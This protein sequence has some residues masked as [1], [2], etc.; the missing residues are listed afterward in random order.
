MIKSVDCLKKMKFSFYQT[1]CN[2][3]EHWWL[4]GIW[5]HLSHCQVSATPVWDSWTETTVWPGE[6]WEQVPPH[7]LGLSSCGASGCVSSVAQGLAPPFGVHVLLFTVHVGPIQTWRHRL[8][9]LLLW[10]PSSPR[11]PFYPNLTIFHVSKSE[12]T[13]HKQDDILIII[14][15]TKR[16][17]IVH[18]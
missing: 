2:K 15:F 13:N 10:R 7:G 3:D 5:A 16:F 11:L 12:F 17:T 8:F 9:L 14:H 1:S 18:F 6:Q 4:L